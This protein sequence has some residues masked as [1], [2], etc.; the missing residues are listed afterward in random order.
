MDM[1]AALHWLRENV[2]DF[3][4]DP[5]NLTVFGHHTGAA[6]VNLLMLSPM[7]QGLHMDYIRIYH[8]K[9][10]FNVECNVCTSNAGK[11][12]IDETFELPS[13]KL[14]SS[15]VIFRIIQQKMKR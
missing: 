4:G 15:A 2:A 3:G 13:I 9:S 14:N 7:A 12:V 6:A 8:L 11:K 1:V 5:R 10:F